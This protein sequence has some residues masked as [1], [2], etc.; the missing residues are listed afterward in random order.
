MHLSLEDLRIIMTSISLM[1]Q[2]SRAITPICKACTTK[3]YGPGADACAGVTV[4][5]RWRRSVRRR[6]PE[7]GDRAWVWEGFVS[8]L[9]SS[10]KIDQSSS[11]TSKSVGQQDTSVSG[12][13]TLQVS[14]CNL[15]RRD[16]TS[17][18]HNVSCIWTKRGVKSL[19]SPSRVHGMCTS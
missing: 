1:L 3:R 17:C 10:A 18:A 19:R 16:G 7:I 2:S 9:V 4:R 12:G 15:T 8:E 11:A 6:R 14:G 13:D 5:W